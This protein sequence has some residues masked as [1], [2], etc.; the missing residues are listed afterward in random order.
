MWGMEAEAFRKRDFEKV[1]R[2]CGVFATG[3]K[4]PG[5]RDSMYRYGLF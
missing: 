2:A 1:L 5:S 4:T 3:K